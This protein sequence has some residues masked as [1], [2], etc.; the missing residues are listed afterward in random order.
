LRDLGRVASF[1]LRGDVGL[2]AFDDDFVAH[3]SR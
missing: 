3:V 2:L 1:D